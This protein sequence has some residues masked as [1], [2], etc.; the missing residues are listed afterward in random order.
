MPQCFPELLN[1]WK[2]LVCPEEPRCPWSSLLCPRLPG[3]WF[4]EYTRLF[5]NLEPSSKLFPLP[6][7]PWFPG[8]F[9]LILKVSGLISPERSPLTAHP[10]VPTHLNNNNNLHLLLLACFKTQHR[11]HL[12]PTW[13]VKKLRH[14]DKKEKK[15]N[16][17]TTTTL[18]C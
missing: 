17:Q 18:S 7:S 11:S 2:W 10:P 13:W 12:I 9:W 4:Q 3:V 16:K 8:H 6:H 15:T 5:I 14:S 1:Q